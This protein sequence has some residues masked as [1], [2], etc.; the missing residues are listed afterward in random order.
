MEQHPVNG[1]TTRCFQQAGGR[2]NTTPVRYMRP[3]GGLPN[4]ASGPLPIDHG[5]DDGEDYS[6]ATGTP[7]VL[8]SGSSDDSN[9]K[10]HRRGQLRAADDEASTPV[11]K[12][13]AKNFVTMVS[14]EPRSFAPPMI[15]RTGLPPPKFDVKRTLPIANGTCY[16]PSPA[17]IEPESNGFVNVSSS[18]CASLSRT[19]ANSVPFQMAVP[20]DQ[21]V[22]NPG[23]MVPRA[24]PHPITAVTMYQPLPALPLVAGSVTQSDMLRRLLGPA[25]LPDVQTALDTAFFP[26]VET[27]RMQPKV[28]H[29]VAKLSNIPFTTTR[30]EIVA[31]L[32]R[33]VKIL[34]D[35]DEPVHI[36][37][38]RTT[39]KTHDAY[40]EF[41][42]L[43]D[44]MRAVDK[45]RA[46][47]AKGR[48]SRLGERPVDM[49]LSSQADLMRDLFPIAR[50]VFW[51]GCVPELL[52]PNPDEPWNHF[53]GFVSEE[54]MTMLVKCVQVPQR[55]Q[56]GVECP[57]R[58]YES[59]ISTLKK[60]PWF[61]PH[62]ITARARHAIFNAT[63]EL[64]YTLRWTVFDAGEKNRSPFLL[65]RRLF[66]RLV[67]A[68]L[69]CP[70][71]TVVQKDDIVFESRLTELEARAFN[72]PRQAHRWTHIYAVSP[73]PG[74]PLDVIEVRHHPPFHF[75][76]PPKKLT[77]P[78]R[79][80]Y[81]ALV[82]EETSRCAASS[83]LTERAELQRR[84][85]D[86]DDYWGFFWHEL[87]LRP[88]QQLDSLTLGQMAHMEL[89]ALERVI[90]RALGGPEPGAI[91]FG[92]GGHFNGGSNN[93]NNG[94]GGANINN[95]G[96]VA[97]YDHDAAIAAAYY[98][99]GHNAVAGAIEYGA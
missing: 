71:F 23:Y 46:T 31:F 65:D 17:P 20:P 44:A 77:L 32:G 97:F 47:I 62:L 54:E 49:S 36:I 25:G 9:G 51:D 1:K 39:S 41:P 33:N 87:G 61:M 10:F 29:G 53:K 59:M 83:P 43:Q 96:P 11:A 78:P 90:R 16:T 79:Q 98:D 37:M 67:H 66:R 74:T 72:Q 6:T 81:I 84:A 73:K 70:G 45:H 57:Q 8:S 60:L 82:R 4:S 15:N 89:A 48:A 5:N 27:V 38:E 63:K 18:A 7:S 24:A 13:L 75:N 52:R 86:T 26:F 94:G 76:T 68:A 85:Q 92:Q 88:G 58:P 91:P 93:N 42:S 2:L 95:A 30:A 64:V 35:V 22:Y 3:I 80:Y 14:T 28:A 21:G 40:V 34:N 50:G 19:S 55:A 69:R 56:Y 12:N 99:A